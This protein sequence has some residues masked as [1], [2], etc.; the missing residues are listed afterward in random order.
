MEKRETIFYDGHC[1]LC[2]GFV[3]FIVRRDRAASFEFAP[4]FGEYFVRKLSSAQQTG[5]PDS[6]AVLTENGK[7]L[8]KSD[9]LVHVLA[10]I[11]GVWKLAASLLGVLPRSLRDF[12]YDAVASVRKSV[13]GTRQDVCP[14]LPPELRNRF[15]L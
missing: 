13:F 12:G 6:A 5:L 2:H 1:G 3:R 10:A 4:L 15:R 11:G 8:V 7:V 9:A 14:A